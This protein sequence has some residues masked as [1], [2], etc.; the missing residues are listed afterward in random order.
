MQGETGSQMQ[1]ELASHCW[2]DSAGSLSSWPRLPGPQGS[3][4]AP[5]CWR[6]H[7][8]GCSQLPTHT[9]ALPLDCCPGR[10]VEE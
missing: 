2:L 10:T 5:T 8:Q 1:T 6:G 3:V 9:L 7:S 4:S